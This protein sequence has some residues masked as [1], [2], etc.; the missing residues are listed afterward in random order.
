MSNV[1]VTFSYVLFSPSCQCWDG[2][3]ST[4]LMHYA[5]RGRTAAALVSLGVTP[6]PWH[7]IFRCRARRLC[8]T[9]ILLSPRARLK[10]PFVC[11]FRITSMLQCQMMNSACIL[12]Y[13]AQRRGG[14]LNYPRGMTWPLS[15]GV[16][17]CSWIYNW[18]IVSSVRTSQLYYNPL[19]F[20]PLTTQEDGFMPQQKGP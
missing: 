14:A 18:K 15:F 11:L 1:N 8:F 17:F 7:P 20:Y 6:S 9:S 13:R 4:P 12:G 19:L 2:F 5:R 3:L 10:L 16:L